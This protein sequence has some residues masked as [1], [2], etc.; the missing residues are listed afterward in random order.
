MSILLLARCLDC[1][2]VALVETSGARCGMPAERVSKAAHELIA[3]C[4]LH[5]LQ[6]PQVGALVARARQGSLLAMITVVLVA[7][8][9]VARD[10]RHVLHRSGLWLELRIVGLQSVRQV[11]SP[12]G[13]RLTS[14]CGSAH[15]LAKSGCSVTATRRVAIL[16]LRLLKALQCVS[17][18]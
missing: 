1:A 18:Q 4:L 14:S 11:T 2:E 6:R 7:R 10:E 15:H 17:S 5:G 12:A 9:E 13:H 16:I 3:R 8:V